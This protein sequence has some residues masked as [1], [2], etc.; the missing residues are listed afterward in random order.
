[1]MK[2]QSYIPPRAEIFWTQFESALL[3]T[4]PEGYEPEGDGPD[5]YEFGDDFAW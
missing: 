3:T 2:T 4:S 5:G 1:M